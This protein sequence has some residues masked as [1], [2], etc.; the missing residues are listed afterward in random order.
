MIRVFQPTMIAIEPTTSLAMTKGSSEAGRPN[1][2]MYATFPEYAPILP[3]PETRNSSAN[4]RR[5]EMSD[6]SDLVVR[7]IGPGMAQ[8]LIGRTRACP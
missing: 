5:P 8:L 6:H 1:D 7:P 3:R 4:N 2:D